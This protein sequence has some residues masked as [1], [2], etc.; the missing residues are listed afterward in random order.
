MASFSCSVWFVR[1]LIDNSGCV[2]IDDMVFGHDMLSYGRFESLRRWCFPLW[3]GETFGTLFFCFFLVFWKS[4]FENAACFTYVG[5][6]QLLH[7]I[8]YTESTVCNGSRLSFGWTNILRRVMYGFMAVEKPCLNLA[9]HCLRTSSLS[10]YDV[11]DTWIIRGICI[12]SIPGVGKDGVL[13]PR[14]ILFTIS[15]F[16]PTKSVRTCWSTSLVFS[17]SPESGTP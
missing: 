14:C 9:M 2:P 12:M 6:E 11:K 4:S 7:G 1:F 10:R 17:H 13:W 8:S 3:S 5:L 16:T 15:G